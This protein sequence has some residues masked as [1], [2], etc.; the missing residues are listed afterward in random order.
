MCYIYLW[1]KH[2]NAA[3]RPLRFEKGRWFLMKKGQMAAAKTQGRGALLVLS[4]VCVGLLVAGGVFFAQWQSAS[5]RAQK[6]GGVMMEEFRAKMEETGNCA[7]AWQE[8][9]EDRSYS[10]CILSFSRLETQ[11]QRLRDVG[12]LSQ[13]DADRYHRFFDQMEE[14]WIL[15]DG[16]DVPMEPVEKLVQLAGQDDF[17]EK[18]APYD[19]FAAFMGED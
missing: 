18:G 4:L 3:D 7:T 11:A 17:W 2:K 12:V 14:T 13:E 8:G 16:Q 1:K 9:Q 6:Q 19:D 15:S 5:S 10:D